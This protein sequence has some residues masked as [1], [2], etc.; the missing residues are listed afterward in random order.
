M[1]AWNG[2]SCR[3]RSYHRLVIENMDADTEVRRVS[4]VA[5]SSQGYTNLLNGCQ[6]H[7]WCFSYTCLRRL[8][9]FWTVVKMSSENTSETPGKCRRL[10]LLYNQPMNSSFFRG[11]MIL[12]SPPSKKNPYQKQA[13]H[14]LTILSQIVFFV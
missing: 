4:P 6:D 14:R 9:T 12:P 10:S 11:K 13:S 5:I 3:Q 8:M 7:G 1:D 2:W